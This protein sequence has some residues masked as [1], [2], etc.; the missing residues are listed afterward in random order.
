MLHMCQRMNIVHERQRII[1]N[2]LMLMQSMP[3]HEFT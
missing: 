2:L 3:M 1:H